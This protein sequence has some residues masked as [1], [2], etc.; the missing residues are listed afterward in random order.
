MAPT[1]S[2]LEPV[3]EALYALFQ[4]A[5]LLALAAGGV[6]TSVPEEPTYPFLWFEVLEQDQRGGFGTKPGD[7]ALPEIGIRLHAFT[8]ESHQ[9]GWV[10]C[11]RIIARAM[12]LLFEDDA[13]TIAGYRVCGTVPFH[14]DVLPFSDQVLNG[15][16]VKELVAMHRLY[17]EEQP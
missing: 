8:L 16:K 10:P 14:D 2:S 13:L 9:E 6:Q 4:D 5:A 3:S 11:Q 7:G 12:A 17:I 1:Y 15:V